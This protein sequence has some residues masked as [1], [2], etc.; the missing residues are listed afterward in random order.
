M[1]IRI[2]KRSSWPVGSVQDVDDAEAARLIAMRAA[3]PV[4]GA[5]LQPTPEPLPFE[6]E[7]IQR[8]IR[9]PKTERRGK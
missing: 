4:H 3:R 5:V 2:L 1:K 6:P 7:P 8:T 9:K